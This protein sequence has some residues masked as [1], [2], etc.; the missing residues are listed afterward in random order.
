MDKFRLLLLNYIV[1]W[2]TDNKVK[3]GRFA[4]FLRLH[5]SL[6]PQT[7]ILLI[8]TSDVSIIKQSG[9]LIAMSLDLAKF[10][11]FGKILKE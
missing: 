1:E 4:P 2:K 6:L 10:R 3:E 9:N 7:T 11:H 8:W 5:L